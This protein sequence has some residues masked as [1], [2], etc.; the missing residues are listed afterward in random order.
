MVFTPDSLAVTTSVADSLSSS[1]AGEDLSQLF[2]KCAVS[3]LV[4]ALVGLEREY[5]HGQKEQLFAGVRTFPLI[6]LFGFVAALLAAHIS[7]WIFVAALLGFASLVIASYIFVA[8]TGDIGATTEIAALLVFLFGALIYWDYIALAVALAVVVT[9]FLSMR[10]TLHTIVGKMVAEDIYA[11]LKF[12]IITVIVLPLL[13]D[14]TFGPLDVLNPRHIWYMV[15]LIAGISF[16]G[17]V[18]VKIFGSQKGIQITGLLGGMVSSTAVTLSFS[19]KSREA[20]RLSRN[21]A[22]AIILASTIMYPRVLLEI[23]AVNQSLAQKMLL[24]IALLVVAGVTVSLFLWLRSR[25]EQVEEVK[26]KNPFE[27]SSAIKF[28]LVFA[29]I[30]FVSKAAQVY[31]GSSGIYGASALAGLTD[32]DAVTLSMANLAKSTI[33]ES[34]AATAILL[35]IISN[36]LV[37]GGITIALGS[38]A[39][40]RYTLPGFALVA[41]VGIAALLVVIW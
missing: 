35:A 3:V 2:Q 38:A 30:L 23:V 31:L 1:H 8:R 12:A 33:S 9:L 4:G 10:V 24:P 28:G 18:L 15:I 41:V 5:A 7:T 34:V 14:R 29:L 26:L 11:T 13:P 19:R 22:A 21:F 32:V 36:T 20:E 16:A 37:K 25:G 40:R 27:L 39:L 17:Y 6:S